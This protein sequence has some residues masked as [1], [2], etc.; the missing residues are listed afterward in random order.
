MAVLPFFRRSAERCR[1]ESEEREWPRDLTT[2]ADTRARLGNKL[3][4]LVTLS[5]SSLAIIEM[6]ADRMIADA[7][8]RLDT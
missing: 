2:E 3:Q 7:L 5:P 6:M 1:T 4:R 8:K